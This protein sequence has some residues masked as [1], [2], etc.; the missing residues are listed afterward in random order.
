MRYKLFPIIFIMLC[1]KNSAH[2][3]E[4][5]INGPMAAVLITSG[6]L[7]AASSFQTGRVLYH[8]YARDRKTIPHHISD[9][10]GSD[11]DACLYG[12]AG[13]IL[14]CVSAIASEKLIQP[15]DTLLTLPFMITREVCGRADRATTRHAVVFGVASICSYMLAWQLMK[16]PTEWYIH[17]RG[18]AIPQQPIPPAKQEV[19]Q[20]P[21]P[22]NLQ[23]EALFSAS[24]EGQ[25]RTWYKKFTP[26]QYEQCPICYDPIQPNNLHIT[27]CEQPKAYSVHYYHTECIND[28]K[29]KGHSDCP[30]CRGIMLGFRM[31]AVL[32]AASPRN[33]LSR[34]AGWIQGH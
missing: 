31:P 2:E 24:L 21:T 32:V 8:A 4:I 27:R 15:F 6:V 10:I 18:L 34:I 22:E 3:Q 7:I 33:L 12:T 19:D 23:K 20:P 14:V 5:D 26:E 28:W 30:T 9:P 25:A 1:G 13:G 29:N 17:T 16:R 11:A